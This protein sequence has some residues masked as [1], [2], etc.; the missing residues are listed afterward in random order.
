MC[1]DFSEKSDNVP[2]EGEAQILF[3]KKDDAISSSSRFKFYIDLLHGLFC[4]G[5]WI[6][7]SSRQRIEQGG[8][9]H[10][11]ATGCAGAHRPVGCWV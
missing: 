6:G 11:I 4:V 10:E 7:T 9:A 5:P 8:H 2:R 1:S 3:V